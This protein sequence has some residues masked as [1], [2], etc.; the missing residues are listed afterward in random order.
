MADNLHAPEKPGFRD[1]A[2]EIV[3]QLVL[4]AI[5]TPCNATCPHCPCEVLQEVIRKLPDTYGHED[6]DPFFRKAK[7]LRPTYW[8]KLVREA[9]EVL[10]THGKTSHFR[11]S[12]YGEPMLHKKLVDMMEL[13][14]AAGIRTSL[15]NNGSLMTEEVSE[16]LI[17]AGVVSVEVSAESHLDEVFKRVKPGIDLATVI[18]NIR[19]FLEVRKKL[20]GKTTLLVSIVDQPAANPFIKETT[21]FYEELGVDEVLVRTFQ[22]WD[23]PELIRQKDLNATKDKLGDNLPCPYPFER[24]MVD[25]GGNY[26]LCPMDD[27]QKIPA[28]GHLHDQTLQEVWQGPRFKYYRESHLNGQF[29]APLCFNCPDRKR[30][31]W[32]HNIFSALDKAKQKMIKQ[33]ERY[34]RTDI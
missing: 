31:S 10:K 17:R 7:H 12:S 25:P 22:T 33:E 3:P 21:A 20:G 34:E 14:C 1:P 11:I 26:R 9:S 24:L 19:K 13:S 23:I 30:R 18:G 29:G 6:P 32:N 2:F 4:F 15:I 8:E 16:R 27:Q 5:N 28:F